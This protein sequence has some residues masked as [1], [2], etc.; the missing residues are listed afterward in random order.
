[1]RAVTVPRYG[2]PEVLEVGDVPTPEPGAG[3][4]AID[5]SHAG[6]NFAE[7]LARSGSIPAFSPPFIPGLE[8][9]GTVRNVGEGV[10]EFRPG[11]RVCALTVSGGY[12][13]VAV[14]AADAT[15][16]TERFA[17]RLSPAQLAAL[18]TIVP[19][20]LAV[21]E[22]GAVGDGAT[23]VVE[24]AAGGM[25]SVLGQTARALGAGMLIGVVGSEDKRGAAAGF[26]YDH[27][28]LREQLA[29]ELAR[30]TDGKGADVILDGVGGPARRERLELLAPTGRLVAFGNASD[31]PEA[32]LPSGLMR[33][34]NRAVLG[35]SITALKAARP[36]TVRELSCRAFELVESGGVEPA[37]TREFPLVQARAAHELLGS[38]Q[39]TGKLVL[40]IEERS[41]G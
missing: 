22:L 30:L 39:S 4:V 18:P 13:S 16:D 10:S 19:T 5:V 9:A 31:Q 36:A 25:G 40:V 21:C 38:G 11:Q 12:A 34:T 26:G 24:A 35:F 29:D 28:I 3:Q 7:V 23:V 32:N 41:A 14:A 27:V 33:T 20:A 37:V 17:D 6:V 2:G 8:V 1:M 15:Y